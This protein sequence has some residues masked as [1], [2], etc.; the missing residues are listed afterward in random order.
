MHQSSWR[1]RNRLFPQPVQ[2]T[3]AA[4][5]LEVIIYVLITW[6]HQA[7]GGCNSML[8]Y[9]N[10]KQLSSRLLSWQLPLNNPWI[11]LGRACMFPSLKMLYFIAWL[12]PHLCFL[13][14]SRGNRFLTQ[15]NLYCTLYNFAGSLKNYCDFRL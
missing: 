10:I 7:D 14:W 9:K 8:R 1:K 6:S 3:G 13:I 2:L 4:K 15:H 11:K 5:I 12:I